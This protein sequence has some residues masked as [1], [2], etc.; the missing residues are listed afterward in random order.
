[1][2][3][4]SALTGGFPSQRPVT[5]SFDVFFHLRLN[6]WLSKQSKRRWIETTSRQLWRHGDDAPWAWIGGDEWFRGQHCGDGYTQCYFHLYVILFSDIWSHWITKRG[7]TWKWML[8]EKNWQ[9]PPRRLNV[10]I[11]IP[12]V[13][14]FVITWKRFPH[15]WTF[16]GFTVAGGF[17]H[18]GSLMCRVDV[19]FAVSLIK[20][21]SKQS[22]CLWFEM[23]CR[24]CDVTDWIQAHV[25]YDVI[26]VSGQS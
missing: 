19:L 21:F 18:K 24:L 1:M 4:F 15:Y 10:M 25:E 8:I 13:H 16:V 5:Q 22:I 14:E 7:K 2:E 3:I 12:F 11:P 26:A 20:L 6:K 17:P 9:R 23:Q